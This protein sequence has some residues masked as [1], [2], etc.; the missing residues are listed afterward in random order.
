MLQGTQVKIFSRDTIQILLV[1]QGPDLIMFP[2]FQGSKDQLEGVW[3][4]T[5]KMDPEDF[6][7]KT[8]FKMHGMWGGV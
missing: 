8:F 6:D 1:C 7:P 3:E 5:D 4:D 2:Y